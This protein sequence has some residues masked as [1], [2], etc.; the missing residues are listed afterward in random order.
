MNILFLTIANIPS[1]Y[2]SGSN[3]YTDLLRE[4]ADRGHSVYV[5]SPVVHRRKGERTLIRQG[6]TTII[7]P[8]TGRIQ[9][10]NFVVKGINTLLLDYRFLRAAKK[11]LKKIPLD[12]ILYSTP[13]LTWNRLLAFLKRCYRAVMVLLLKDI[14]P[15]N[16]VD[17]GM[18]SEGGLLYRYFREKEKRVYALSDHIGCMSEANREYVLRH[19]PELS[20]DMVG[21]S[22]NSI[23]LGEYHRVGEAHKEAIRARYGIPPGK[24]AFAFVGN[25]GK[26]HAVSHIIRCMDEVA[27]EEQVF[28]VCCCQ[29]TGYAT[30]SPY[31]AKQPPGR[32]L[33][34]PWLPREQFDELVSCCDVGLIFLDYRFTIPNFPSRLLEYMKQG[35]PVLAATD[36]NTDLGKVI[37][38]GSFGWWCPS[39]D[40]GAFHDQIRLILRTDTRRFGENARR[41]LEEHYD[42]KAQYAALMEEIRKLMVAKEQGREGRPC[43]QEI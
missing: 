14:F 6:N 3:I 20:P 42:V 15:Q 25:L 8:V 10:T 16:A 28:F 33:L 19:N 12:V 30:F 24:K 29:G 37:V 35:L 41:Y 34:L 32:I 17:L 21:V 7:R 2:E 40:A 26:L 43:G 13:P 11:Y 27:D 36:E 22:P 9:K 39:N 23:A 31:V 1:I 4:F 5:L 38:E 18:F